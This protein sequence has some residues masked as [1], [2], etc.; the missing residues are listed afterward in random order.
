MAPPAIALASAAAFGISELV[1]WLVYTT[2]KRPL[3]Q[4]VLISSAF[5]APLDSAAFWFLASFSV[6]GTFVLSTVLT[7]IASKLLGAYVVYRWLKR[8][9]MNN[10][11]N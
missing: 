2:S 9:E 6:A 3:S 10:E 4:R 1:D 5:S 8:R 11:R 7:S